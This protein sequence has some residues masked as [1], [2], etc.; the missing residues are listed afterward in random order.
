VEQV[1]ADAS[2]GPLAHPPS[3]SLPA[4]AAWL[5]CAAISHN[6]LGAAACPASLACAKARAATVRRDLIDVV[7]RAAR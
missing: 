7:A 4:N 6:L 3:G 2:D 5:A 1:F